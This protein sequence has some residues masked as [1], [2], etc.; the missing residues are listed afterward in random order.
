MSAPLEL[1]DHDPAIDALDAETRRRLGELWRERAATE[2]GAGWAFALVV[3]ELYALGADTRVL[4]LATRGAHDEVRHAQLCAHLAS[5]YLGEPVE[6]RPAEPIALPLHEGADERTRMQLHVV[7]LAISE[8]LAAG[9]L[10][11][12][13]ARCEAALPELVA[14]AH[15]EDDIAHARVG[16]AHMASSAFAPERAAVAP[17]VPRLIE[18]NL[19][20]WRTRIAELPVVPAHGYPAHEALTAALEETARDVLLPGFRHVGL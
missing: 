16:W 17:W 5:V 15:L 14:R 6:A 4:A 7:G 9:F 2:M 12:C 10:Q 18:A 20:H 11:A 3:T 1:P 19:R 13:L 8:T